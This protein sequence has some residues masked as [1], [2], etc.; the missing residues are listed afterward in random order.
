MCPHA[1][2]DSTPV[3]KNDMVAIED[4]A[5]GTIGQPAIKKRGTMR[6]PNAH[7]NNE[8]K[9]PYA[10]RAS[11]LLSNICN[12]NIIESTLRGG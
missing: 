10:A 5:N 7:P 1:S 12:F 11:D 9:N 4:G 8:P 2:G 3:N 6:D